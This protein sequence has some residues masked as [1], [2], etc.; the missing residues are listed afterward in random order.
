V[1]LRGQFV[2]VITGSAVPGR[3]GSIDLSAGGGR[4]YRFVTGQ[5][6]GPLRV[7]GHHAHTVTL[8][9]ADGRHYVLDLRSAHLEAK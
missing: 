5:M 6:N 9:A 4:Y 3:S 1:A 2:R 7:V 8:R